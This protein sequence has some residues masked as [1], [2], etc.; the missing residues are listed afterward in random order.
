[1]IA[2]ATWSLL[3]PVANEIEE[4]PLYPNS[5]PVVKAVPECLCL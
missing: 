4:G 2:I 3:P 5:A 1:M